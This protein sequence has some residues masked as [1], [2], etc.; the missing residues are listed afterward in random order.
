[1]RR[2]RAS[3]LTARYVGALL[4][5]AAVLIVGQLLVQLV[6]ERQDGD[7]RVVNLAGRQR[8]LS[9]RL[10]ML[11]LAHRDPRPVTTEWSASQDALRARDNSE[12]IRTLFEAIDGDHRAMLAAARAGDAELA[13]AHQDAFLAGMDRIVATYE[14]EAQARVIGLRRV[15]LALFAIAMCALAIAG[16]FVFRPA[17]RD[18]RAYLAA[19]DR[20]Q[21]AV[22]DVSDRERRRIAADLH[23]GLGQHLV[24]I[25]FLLK[26]LR[27][28]DEGIREI[29]ALLTEAIEHTRTLARGLYSQTLEAD[30]LSA[31]LR[32]LAAQTERRFGVECHVEWRGDEPPGPIGVHVHRIAGEAVANAAK[33]ASASAIAIT[34]SSNREAGS[35]ELVL[36][37]N[38]DGI[39]IGDHGGDGLGL[40][41]MESR[42]KLIGGSLRVTAREPR[43][44][45]VTCRIPL[46]PAS[47]MDPS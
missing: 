5:V 10:C 27:R 2:D 18:L 32:E 40:H 8:M 22:V 29:A 39:G 43:G 4:A 17:V 34:L 11:L 15:E 41:M 42:A 14:A 12:A 33:H 45:T 24:G 19:R 31:A 1:M 26:A 23:D 9:Q 36:E 13:L 30:G 20:A 37:V 47:T 25:S 35:G 46:G 7:A 21:Q 38:D 16:L 28:D 44:T 6:L 3:V